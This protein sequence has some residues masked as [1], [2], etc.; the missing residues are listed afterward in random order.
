MRSERC[1]Q[2]LNE[3]I[4]FK[5]VHFIV[6]CCIRIF[7]QYSQRKQTSPCLILISLLFDDSYKGKKGTCPS[8]LAVVLS[9]RY[10]THPVNLSSNAV[11]HYLLAFFQHPF[12]FSFPLME[13]HNFNICSLMCLSLSNISFVSQWTGPRSLQLNKRTHRATSTYSHFIFY[14]CCSSTHTSDCF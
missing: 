10:N 1:S 9:G 13:L 6:S 3:S 4:N 2:K 7:W 11:A 14:H 8:G 12:V 5:S